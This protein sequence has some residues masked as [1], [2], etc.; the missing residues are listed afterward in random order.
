MVKVP[1]F[2][3]KRKDGLEYAGNKNES[4]ELASLS[5][6][7]TALAIMVLVVQGRLRLDENVSKYY[8]EFIFKY[9]RRKYEVSIQQLLQHTAGVSKKTLCF[10][11]EGMDD[12]YTA[13]KNISAFPLSNKPGDSYEYA[14]GGYVILGLIIEKVSGKKYSNF[15]EES[16][17]KPLCMRNTNAS[18]TPVSGT[19]KLLGRI[20]PKTWNGCR[21]FAACGYIVSTLEDMNIWLSSFSNSNLIKNTDI[22]NAIDFIKN[23]EYFVKTND[24]KLMY[25]FGWFFDKEKNRY[26]HD[27][28][29]PMYSTYME[30][31]QDGDEYGFLAVANAEV[32]TTK[33]FQ[34][35]DNKAT[36][37]LEKNIFSTI[38]KKN[39][40][41]LLKLI[42]VSVIILLAAVDWKFLSVFIL[43][44]VI[45]S[46]LTKLKRL[47][48]REML[49][50]LSID[51]VFDIYLSIL[52][53]VEIIY[54][55]ITLFF[56]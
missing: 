17:F 11:Y 55:G 23:K 43:S 13:A 48:W 18:G 36:K 34:L 46:T 47:F 37:N 52:L 24:K 14:T 53:A 41:I 2:Y 56:T 26:F 35:I 30:F 25:G 44:L 21:A 9:K 3:L 50:W 7:F 31:S 51:Q 1:Y 33:M 4:F 28:L 27:G 6:S 38:Q 32:N 10:Q 19:K 45:F 5:K 20:M 12:I 15:M 42:S 49:M 39:I 16:I 22:K 8:P 40:V 29:N 54:F